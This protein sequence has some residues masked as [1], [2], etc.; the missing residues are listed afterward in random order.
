MIGINRG[1]KIGRAR[2]GVLAAFLAGTACLMGV[3]SHSLAV[4][5]QRWMHT[6]EADFEPGKVESTVV[7][8][9]GDI[10][11]SAATST[12]ATLTEQ[13]G[14]VFDLQRSA[15]G[16]IYMA[17]GP[18]T[19]RIL[20][21]RAGKIEQVAELENE[22]VFTLDVDAKGRLLVGVSGD[23][24][25]LAVL[26]GDK[27]VTLVQLDGVRY[28]WD[29]LVAGD[30]VFLATGADGRVLMVDLSKVGKPG[31]KA[32]KPATKPA[33]AK[34]QPGKAGAATAPGAKEEADDDDA[35]ALPAGV[36]ELFKANQAN[37]LC[38]GQD[39]QGR[40]YAGTDTDGLVYRFTLK[41]DGTVAESFVL[42][43][44]PEPEVGALVV[45]PDGTVYLGTADANEARP[46][47][48]AA[49]TTVEAGRPDPADLGVDHDI[50]PKPGD[51]PNVP[52]KPLPA[53]AAQPDKAAP[54]KTSAPAAAADDAGKPKAKKQSTLPGTGAPAA[55]PIVQSP[56]A[57]PQSSMQ[58][59]LAET[60]H[61][62][63]GDA[64]AD[65]PTQGQRDQ[66][67]QLI[68]QRLAEARK[69]GTLQGADNAHPSPHPKRP[70]QN[71]GEKPGVQPNQ[72]PDMSMP[73]TRVGPEGNA[74]Y[75]ISPDGF[76]T[77]LFREACIVLKIIP[78]GD[79]LLVAT[80]NEG[81]LYRIDPAAGEN[82]V[83]ARLE[84]SQLPA[85]IRLP[86]NS[87]LLGTANPASLVR[88]DAGFA[89]T[90]VFTSAPLDAGH[91]SL[92]GKFNITLTL[93]PETAVLVETRSGNVQDPDHAAWSAWSKPQELKPDAKID[94]FAPRQFTIDSPPA[95]FFQ[96]RL[97]LKGDGKA[98]P[99]IDRFD[100]AY[101]VPNI[102]PS[103]KSITIN[104]PDSP[105][106][107]DNKGLP[108]PR[109]PGA[110]PPHANPNLPNQPNNPG[111]FPLDEQS[112]AAVPIEWEGSDPN[113][114]TLRYTLEYQQAGTNKWLPLAKDLEVTNFE[115]Q[116]RRVPDGRYIVRV[117]ASDAPS[118]TPDM[119]LTSSRNSDPIVVDNTPPAVEDLKID[120]KNKTATLA[121]KAVDALSI[122][123]DINYGID[124][125]E[126]WNAVL[127]EDL[128]FDSTTETFVVRIVDLSPGPHVVT[129][130]VV[131]TRG[132]AQYKAAAFEVK[133]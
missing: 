54:A 89:K 129:L 126:K 99:V 39:K 86:D 21:H 46:E 75:R 55:A 111:A 36:V 127:P 53:D 14:V 9:L 7:T 3:P 23:S 19:A 45:M 49:P 122:I 128:I 6:T 90:G 116:T 2:A 34:P 31:A 29:M 93:P 4:Q 85:M 101:V 10:K 100:T 80:G 68:R 132:N 59:R 67:R 28:I 91:T 63:E 113:G 105:K 5:P 27:L 121:G 108:Q 15:D 24:S 16:T 17:T 120:V 133:P 107:T 69:T 47:R 97:T 82:T 94:A 12:T 37:V 102:K 98:T 104:F 22:Q 64:A 26:E 43:D 1:N 117:V 52:P 115:W 103:I 110:P 73:G 76:V 11:L 77:E 87:V 40:I 33:R 92:W 18:D 13:A 44:A 58:Q 65:E 60:L 35:K 125:T 109:Q 30:R 81:R 8:N 66:L 42:F 62:S 32:D 96:Y 119:A 79:K 57:K 83:V 51:L 71:P 118:N 56:A 25:R 74:V 78:D 72:P 106:P 123:R 61:L 88:I 70:G 50:A 20:R 41:P 95:R 124:T 112:I 84:P 131:D 48:L 130:R 114:D 38:L